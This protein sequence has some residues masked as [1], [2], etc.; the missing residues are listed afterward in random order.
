MNQ[1]AFREWLNYKSYDPKI[2]ELLQI[3]ETIC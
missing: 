3:D 2:E 1:S